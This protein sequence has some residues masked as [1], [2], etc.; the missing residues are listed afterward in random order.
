MKKNILLLTVLIHFNLFLYAQDNT[1][2]VIS[3]GDGKTKDEA[4]NA[5]L[6]HCIEK[7]FG[8]FV[9]TNTQVVNDELIK[10]DIGLSKI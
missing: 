2:S 4:T 6:R 7:T 9:T 5:A 8:V 3:F 10:D 1:V